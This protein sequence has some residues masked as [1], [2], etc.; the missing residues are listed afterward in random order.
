M[1]SHGVVVTVVV[2]SHPSSSVMVTVYV[3]D[4]SG[5]ELVI[6]VPGVYVPLSVPA[7]SPGTEVISYVTVEPVQVGEGGQVMSDNE[8]MVTARY[9]NSS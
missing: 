2:L 9:Y 5:D 1:H 8:R 4:A 3:V 6:A 7:A